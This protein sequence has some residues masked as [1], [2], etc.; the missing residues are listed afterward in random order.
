MNLKKHESTA[1]TLHQAALLEMMTYQ[2]GDV[3]DVTDLA[4]GWG[5]HLS[6]PDWVINR[7]GNS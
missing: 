2:I 4:P 6:S 5:G 7:N 3:D 1:L